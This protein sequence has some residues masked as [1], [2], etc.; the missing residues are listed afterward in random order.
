MRKT[1]Q[2]HPL[3]FILRFIYFADFLFF[4]CKKGEIHVE[5]AFFRLTFAIDVMGPDG[6]MLLRS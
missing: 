5:G 4:R 3:Y 2:E 6:G 1:Q